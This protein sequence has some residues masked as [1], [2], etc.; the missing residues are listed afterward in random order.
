MLCQP[1]SAH[2]KLLMCL[3]L[4]AVRLA[5]SLCATYVPITSPLLSMAYARAKKGM[6]GLF[7]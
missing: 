5:H 6:G 3:G 7:L 2:A 4:Q 1:G